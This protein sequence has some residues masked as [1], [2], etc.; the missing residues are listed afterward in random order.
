[1][2]LLLDHEDSFVHTLAGYVAELGHTPRVVRDDA[3]TLAEIEALSPVGIILSPGPCTPQDCP[4]A[5]EVVRRLG[6]TTPIFGVCLGHQVIAAALGATVARA[7][8]PRHGMTSV[9]HHDGRGVFRDVP[10]PM[11]A[12]RYHSLVVR[13]DTLPPELEISARAEDGEVMAIRHVTWP[14]EGV[15]FHPES[16]L[17]EHGHAMVGN[18]L[19]SS[20][21]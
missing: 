10:S 15:Q 21:P 12:T 7:N 6:A 20:R 13:G 5:I 1:V 8:A 16:V 4:L 9:I 3:I 2:I 11:Q 18:W 19:H 14:V 17:T